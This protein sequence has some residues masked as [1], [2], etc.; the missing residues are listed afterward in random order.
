M[1]AAAVAALAALLS[2]ATSS[3]GAPTAPSNVTRSSNSLS[4]FAVIHAA[5]PSTAQQGVIHVKSDDP[6]AAAPALRTVI[7]RACAAVDFGALTQ[8][9]EQSAAR[10]ARY[11]DAILGSPDS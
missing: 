9:M 4:T 3:F 5:S 11:Y 10:T 7:A 8:T 6:D 2:L 1:Q